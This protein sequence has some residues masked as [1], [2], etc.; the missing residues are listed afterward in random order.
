MTLINTF[1]DIL[2]RLGY[3]HPIHPTEVHMPIGLVVSAFVFAGV[4]LVFRRQKLVLTPRYCILLA[5]IWVFPTMILG[6]MDWQHFYHGAWIMPIKVKLVTAH[7][8]AALLG[9]SIFLGRMYG[10]T[11]LKV[12]PVYFLC[13][14]AVVVLGYFGGQLTFG[15]RTISGP[16]KYR[17]GEQIFAANCTACHP[18]GGNIL[19]PGKPILH[20][21][22]LQNLDIFKIWLHHPAQPMPSFSSSEISD[23]Q[24][25]ALYEYIQN[26]LNK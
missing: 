10:S 19:A 3:H 17:T 23:D 6:I 15:G 22:L 20:S 25:K 16:E 4:A 11:S 13:L 2:N 24:A 5:F 9:V 21:A 18:D 14:C 8:L 1:Y 7:I 12:L 26:V